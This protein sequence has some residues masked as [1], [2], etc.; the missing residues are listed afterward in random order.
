MYPFCTIY[1][2]GAHNVEGAWT[3][4]GTGASPPTRTSLLEEQL[5]LQHRT[6]TEARNQKGVASLSG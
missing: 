2:I 4:L 5:S 3:A 1:E 6:A